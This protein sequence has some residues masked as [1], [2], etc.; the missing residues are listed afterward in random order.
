MPAAL[1][2]TRDGLLAIAR[3]L[4]AAPQVL[5][6][7][8]ELLQDINT[9]LDQIANDIRKDAA[10]AA[11]VIRVSNSVVYGGR[12]TVSSV[13]EAVG[14]VGFSEVVRLV[15]TATVAGLVDRELRCYHVGVDVVREAL[16]LHALAS[17]AV[18]EAA[19]LNR[20]TAYV[21]GLLRGIGM[22]VLDRYAAE[23]LPVQQTFDP[24]EFETYRQWEIARFGLDGVGVTTMALDDWRLPEELV[25]AMELHLA[26]P[27]GEDEIHRLA[28]VM[29]VAGAIATEHGNALPGEVLHWAL[30]P[31]KLATAGLDEEQ[32]AR[33]S[34]QACALFDQ[35]RHALY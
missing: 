13:D 11:R 18:G 35:Q 14:R 15:G 24:S 1:N 8:S 2:P 34:E 22:M 7:I 5:A 20:H 4:P 33:A 31:E 3:T 21:A 6:G 16:L 27:E 28:S 19:G 26:P 23:R 10:L 12:G 30:T 17:E 25:G 9:D 32:L 29:N